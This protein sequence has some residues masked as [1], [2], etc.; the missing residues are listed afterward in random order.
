V[1]KPFTIISAL[2]LLLIA[3]A[4]AYR[5]YSGYDITVALSATEHIMVP[6]WASW[7]CA[8]VLAFLGIMLFVEAPRG[9]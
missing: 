4:H 3:A 1:S 2:L 9:K 6:I 8:A 7:V 5:A